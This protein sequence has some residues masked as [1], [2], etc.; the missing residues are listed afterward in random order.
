VTWIPHFTVRFEIIFMIKILGLKLVD[1]KEVKTSQCFSH[2]LCY[3][4][5]IR[6]MSAWFVINVQASSADKQL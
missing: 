6:M 2:F 1:E 4:C 5:V 3:S